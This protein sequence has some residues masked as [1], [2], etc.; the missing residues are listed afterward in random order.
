MSDA[1]K[2]LMIEDSYSDAECVKT[3]LEMSGRNASVK[4]IST[5]QDFFKEIESTYDVIICDYQLPDF[6]ALDV[7]DWIAQKNIEI[8]LIVVSGAIKEEIAVECIH[9]GAADYLIKDRLK[10]LPFAIEKAI[11]EAQLKSETAKKDRLL[12][13]SEERYRLL[14]ETVHDYALA[15]LD[16]DGCINMWNRGAK[17]V[18]GYTK[19]E[20]LGQHVSILYPDDATSSS[21][22]NRHLE[23]S[24]KGRN[25]FDGVRRRK[26]GSFI[27]TSFRIFPF[28]TDDGMV[29]GYSLLAYD[30]TEKVKL[31]ETRARILIIEKEARAKAEE[32]YKTAEKTNRLKDEF[33]S[34]IS[35]ELRTPLGAIIGWSDLMRQNKIQQDEWRSAI[36]IIYKNA[37]SQLRIIEDLLD[38]AR[39]LSGKLSIET[40]ALDIGRMLHEAAD[41]M[42]VY[43]KSK[44]IKLIVQMPEV[45]ELITAD[46]MRLKQ[47]VSNLIMNAIKFSEDG[48]EVSVELE[49]LGDGIK[50]SVTDHGEGIDPEFLPHIFAR[51]RQED[52]SKARTHGGLGLGLAIVRHLVEL[53][54]GMVRAQSR[55]K[56]HGAIFS[57]LLPKGGATKT[58]VSAELTAVEPPPPPPPVIEMVEKPAVKSNGRGAELDGARI[59]LIEDDDSSRQLAQ[60]Y[61]ESAGAKV[62]AF[63][64][65]VHALEVL[66]D[67]ATDLI[68]CDVGLPE[69]DGNAFM[70][71]IRA[72][73]SENFRNLPSLA[74]TA[75][76][77]VEDRQNCLAAGFSDYLVKPTTQSQLVSKVSGL[78]A[79]RAQ[80]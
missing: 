23:Q 11:R 39:I 57:V 62:V 73:A 80:I 52:S 22:A 48:G 29:K 13:E 43:A 49:D 56:G 3:L 6:D 76:A 17:T 19:N 30:I 24:A 10:R 51:F 21:F 69:L 25:K 47:I 78:Y 27:S 77:A 5:K 20:I 36:E 41:S 71:K 9:R 79:Q 8:P 14:F 55:G 63:D 31:D 50:I 26:D 60:Y 53:H 42:Q 74:L 37:R 65:A 70:T 75:Y 46:P 16:P 32:A 68:V 35:H 45:E 33:L 1:L 54:G 28:F 38:A 15:G 67:T 12:R 2:I 66:E 34:I 18:F 64:S 72:S 7:L 61:L 59:I 40:T 44:N 4:L 58:A